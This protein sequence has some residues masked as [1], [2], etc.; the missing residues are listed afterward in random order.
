MVQGLD[1][2]DPVDVVE[3][4]PS[5]S[6]QLLSTTQIKKQPEPAPAS[7]GVDLDV[8]VLCLN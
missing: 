2:R 8:S 7:Q 3:I 1:P 5:G 4:R 6:W